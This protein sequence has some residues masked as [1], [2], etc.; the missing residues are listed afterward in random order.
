MDEVA[1]ADLPAS[2]V[3]WWGSRAGG[4]GGGGRKASKGEDSMWGNTSWA[5]PPAADS[6]VSGSG[7]GNSSWGNPAASTSKSS[8]WDSSEKGKEVD[9]SGNSGWDNAGAWGDSPWGNGGSGWGDT[10]VMSGWGSWGDT[11]GTP[12]RGTGDSSA[13]ADREEPE[14]PTAN[15]GTP[16]EP[17]AMRER[18]RISSPDKEGWGTFQEPRATTEEAMDSDTP[19][20]AQPA[21]EFW[22]SSNTTVKGESSVPTPADSA[23]STAWAIAA[24]ASEPSPAARLEREDGKMDSESPA[25]GNANGEAMEVDDWEPQVKSHMSPSP[26]PP[27]PAGV[28]RPNTPPTQTPVSSSSLTRK[29]A[30]SPSEP[31]DSE[32]YTRSDYVKYVAFLLNTSH[33]VTTHVYDH[34]ALIESA[35]CQYQYDQAQAL[36][37]KDKALRH[38][39]AYHNAGPRAIEKLTQLGAEHAAE[40]AQAQKR[41]NAAA[42]RLVSISEYYHDSSA[43][44]LDWVHAEDADPVE[45]VSKSIEDV[46]AW[47]NKAAELAKVPAALSGA[48]HLSDSSSSVYSAATAAV[49]LELTSR[50]TRMEKRVE[51]QYS[52]LSQL[53]EDSEQMLDQSLEERWTF[54]SSVHSKTKEHL[55]TCRERKATINAELMKLNQDMVAVKEMHRHLA[56]ERGQVLKEHHCLNTRIVEVRVHWC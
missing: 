6:S 15:P 38:S 29:R 31:K 24:L 47:V 48:Q 45:F 28:H 55:R 13:A 21:N 23:Q 52:Y 50:L 5:D 39:K 46:K 37:A 33:F 32:A 2:S 53:Q 1:K 36:Q 10:T 41:R 9:R 16:T 51:D 56:E 35:L 43:L 11:S 20:N 8:G 25:T 26:P 12:G 3:D 14:P 22:G 7:W 4:S 44:P 27:P 49:T 42:K 19:S 18:T 17:K 54:M 30:R 34:R 40:H